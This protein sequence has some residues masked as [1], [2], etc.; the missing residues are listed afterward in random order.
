VIDNEGR[1]DNNRC[2]LKTYL[3]VKTLSVGPLAMAG[4]P[5]STLLSWEIVK[6][7]SAS[8]ED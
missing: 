4:M 1:H 6:D 2:G 3:E 5:Q 7:T 8:I